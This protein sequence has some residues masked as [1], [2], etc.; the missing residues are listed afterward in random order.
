[1]MRSVSIKY[2]NISQLKSFALPFAD[3]KNCLVQIFSG[4]I[5]KAFLLELGTLLSDTLPLAHI[6]GATTDGEINDRD[7]TVQESV[8]SISCFDDV[9]LMSSFARGG[10]SYENATAL[11]EKVGSDK[12]RLMIVFGD[13]MH[14][15]GDEILK[16]LD[17]A[18]KEMIV[19][20]GLAGD[21]GALKQTFV[22]HNKTVLEKGLVGVAFEGESL[23][24]NT[25]HSFDWVPIGNEMHITSSEK[26]RVYT[27]N[28]IPAKEIYKKYL[29][30]SAALKL[31]SIG[32]EFPLIIEETGVNIARAIVQVHEDDSLTFS[33]NIDEGTRVR[34]GVGNPTLI[35][36]NGRKSAKIIEKYPIEAAFIYSCMARRRFLQKHITTELENYPIGVPLTGFFTYG[37]F[38]STKESKSL[39]NQSVT[40][41][42]LSEKEHPKIEYVPPV[43]K[44][45]S[46]PKE[47]SQTLEAMAHLV[48]ETS[49]DV[50]ELNETL[51]QRVID[52]V[53]ELE[54][55]TRFFQKIFETANEG[56][57]VINKDKDTIMANNAL[58]NMLGYE[59]NIFI[60]KP[61]SDFVDEKNRDEFLSNASETQGGQGGKNYEMDLVHKNGKIVHAL[62]STEVLCD[63]NSEVIGSFAM[64]TNITKRKQAED[65]L[66]SFNYLLEEKIAE[67][68]LKNHSKDELMTKQMRMAQMGE[69]I[70]MIAHQWRQPLST[71]S[72]IVASTQM[73]LSLNDDEDNPIYEDLEHVNE[74]IQFLSNTIDDFR[75]FF[76]PNKL[77]SS[78]RLCDLLDNALGIINQS[79]IQANVD[80]INDYEHMQRPMKLY[81]SELVQVFLNLIK[82]SMD[83]LSE[84]ELD[85]AYIC[86]RGSEYDNKS[87]LVFED[88]GGGISTEIMQKIFEPYF[89]TKNEKNGTGLGLYMSKMII[90][91][92]CDGHLIVENTD[93]G[94][95]FTIALP[96]VKEEQGLNQ[97]L[98]KE[99]VSI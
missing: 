44:D 5:D 69:M 24:I 42:M 15:N 89:T 2:K 79:L 52:K 46:T 33:G 84:Q 61:I 12:T 36:K 55:S 99:E 62:F 6:I 40:I 66:V 7:V 1:M 50:K 35:L 59:E 85:R 23:H 60:G 83:V 95:R 51:E 91:E 71:I 38:Y 19:A 75:N 67:E 16:S 37:E 76:S 96:H 28:G 56:I 73:G 57:W 18:K 22:L 68:V 11:Y 32:V 80:I 48:N 8:V 64:V 65:E 27:I 77:K 70:S 88:N 39:L 74:H 26:N 10:N 4:V 21:N 31:P 94:A 81:S 25:H 58:C 17:H 34:F 41:L 9:K 63:E 43:E 90:E 45:E 30:E 14:C 78:V 82:N 86:I 54:K 29:G 53:N 47:Y 98:E 93:V 49:R 3:E 92:H 72:A 87:V 13:G 20:G 97:I